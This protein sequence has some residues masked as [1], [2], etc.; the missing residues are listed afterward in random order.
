MK[1]PYK[2]FMTGGEVSQITPPR[3]ILLYINKLRD[4]NLIPPYPSDSI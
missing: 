1:T 2:Y 3:T 4:T